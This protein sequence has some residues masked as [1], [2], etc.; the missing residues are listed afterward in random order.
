MGTDKDVVKIG[1]HVRC[2]HHY[3]YENF[4]QNPATDYLDKIEKD[5]DKIMKSRDLSKTKIFL[6]TLMQPLVDRL[7]AKYDVVV[8]PDVPRTANIYADWADIASEDPL[9]R[10]R[11]AIVDVWCLSKCDELWGGA[12]NIMVFSGCLNPELKIN[13]LPSLSDCNSM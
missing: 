1:I 7:C 12:S 10:Q 6:A 4:D 13:L 11:D 5:I 3:C 2:C 8:V 9:N